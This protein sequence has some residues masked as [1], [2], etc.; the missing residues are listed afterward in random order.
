MGE[1]IEG[2][3][4]SA[5][6]LTCAEGHQIYAVYIPAL[7][8]YGFACGLCHE[9]GT[10]VTKGTQVLAIGSIA[11]IARHHWQ[12]IKK[13]DL[14]LYSETKAAHL[15]CGPK[16]HPLMVFQLR[17]GEGYAF[18]CLHCKRYSQEIEDKGTVLSVFVLRELAKP[19]PKIIIH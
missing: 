10:T 3:K 11:E 18:G 17:E 15:S 12:G 14:L 19:E 7:S 16:Q 8:D 9:I 13:E 5:L 6:P 1:T 2:R 4:S